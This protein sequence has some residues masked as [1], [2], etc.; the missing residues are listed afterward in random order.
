MR[1]ADHQRRCGRR[2]RRSPSRRGQ[3]RRGPPARRR[4]R[5]RRGDRGRGVGAIARGTCPRGSDGSAASSAARYARSARAGDP[6]VRWPPVRHRPPAVR[7]DALPRADRVRRLAR[8][9]GR[10]ARGPAG[11]RLRG[12]PAGPGQAPVRSARRG[13]RRPG[14]RSPRAPAHRRAGGR[15]DRAAATCRGRPVPRPPRRC[16]RAPRPRRWPRRATPT[17]RTISSTASTAR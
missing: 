1:C 6:G 3:G 14:G 11:A 10:P 8:L 13:R 16:R 12:D 7:G 15:G 9:R 2:L 17:S 4:A 5:R